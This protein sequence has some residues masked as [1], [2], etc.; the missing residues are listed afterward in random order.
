MEFLTRATFCIDASNYNARRRIDKKKKY[1]HILFYLLEKGQFN[2]REILK[3]MDLLKGRLVS[4]AGK[5]AMGHKHVKFYYLTLTINASQKQI[6]K[7]QC[8]KS[9]RL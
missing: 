1:E 8:R 2:N 9:S 6:K 5:N 7:Q 4:S 3:K